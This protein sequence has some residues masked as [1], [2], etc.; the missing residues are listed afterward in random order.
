MQR[1]FI[2]QDLIVNQEVLMNPE[3]SHHIKNVMRLAV[4]DLVIVNTFAGLCFEAKIVAFEKKQAKLEF[5]KALVNDYQPLNLDLGLT[6]IK[7]DNFE[8]ALQ[9][10]TE[11]G[12]RKIIPLQTERSIIKIDD[13]AKKKTRYE[14]ICKE[15][16]EQ[17]ERTVMPIISN[18][19]DL[20]QLD[21]NAYDYRF[22]A[23]ERED[24]VSLKTQI[25]TIK[26][27]EKVLVIIGPEGGFSEKEINKLKSSGFI[28]I[29]LGKTILRAET[30]A[31]YVASVFRHHW[32]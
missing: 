5:V 31:I 24:E 23:Y 12:V 17:S 7:K 20:E 32:G 28:S 30:A 21:S 2:D 11:L 18:Y 22:F 29:S 26:K 19:T 3:D 6:L 8:L 16:S 15:A 10:I 25:Q 14:L 27:S 4:N 13:Y 9:K 1:Y